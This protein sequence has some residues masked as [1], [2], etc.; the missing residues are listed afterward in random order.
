MANDLSV[1]WEDLKARLDVALDALPATHPGGE[2]SQASLN[3]FCDQAAAEVIAAIARSGLTPSATGLDATAL[4]QAQRLTVDGAIKLTY[5]Q[6][7]RSGPR[8]TEARRRWEDG[9]RRYENSPQALSGA[10]TTH[11]SNLDV[12]SPPGVADEWPRDRDSFTGRRFGF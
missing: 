7:G 3:V 6:I 10:P 12:D 2:L 5:E 8:Y 9:L 1:T 4:L 11:M